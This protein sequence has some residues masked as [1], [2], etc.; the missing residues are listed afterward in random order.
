[1]DDAQLIVDVD[2]SIYQLPEDDGSLE[3][4]QK[5]ILLRVIEQVP[6]D[7]QLS[8]YEPAG[9]GLELGNEL[10][11]VGVVAV[12]EDAALPLYHF[13]LVGG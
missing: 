1:M 12:P 2:D 13:P 9:L 6:L 4:L 3:F 8:H 7:H 10:D 5:T 11:D